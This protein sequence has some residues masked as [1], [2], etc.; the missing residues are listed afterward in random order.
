[1]A[2]APYLFFERCLR[3]AGRVTPADEFPD[4]AFHIVSRD[5]PQGTGMYKN[6][7][8]MARPPGRV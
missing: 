8:G 2:V 7:G 5:H 6:A 1:M 4:V 3:V